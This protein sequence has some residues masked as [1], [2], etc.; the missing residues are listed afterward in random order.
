[1]DDE[2]EAEAA[3]KALGAEG[4]VTSLG[5]EG[6]VTSLGAEGSVTSLGGAGSVELGAEAM[7]SGAESEAAFTG[8]HD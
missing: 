2:T 7:P 6:S 1:M 4:S 8:Y 3:T 5:A